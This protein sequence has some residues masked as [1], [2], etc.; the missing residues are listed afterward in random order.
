MTQLNATTLD[1]ELLHSKT[2]LE[3]L[4]GKPVPN[5]ATPYGDYNASVVNGIKK[6]YASHRSVDE[7]YNSKDNFNIYNLRVQNVLDT[8][9]A[10]EVENWINT[11]KAN[12]T[13]LILVYHRV[14]N[15]PGPYDTTPTLFAQH[16]E[17][18]KASGISVKTLQEA[19]DIVKPQLNQ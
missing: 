1:Y 11:A 7:G 16:L 14:A 2:Y 18:I 3:K 17:K 13:W 19:L 6:Y 12:K 4:I 15:D 10:A 5:F 8:T 9:T